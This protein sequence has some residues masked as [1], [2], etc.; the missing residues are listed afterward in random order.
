[1]TTSR[2]ES[3]DHA[4]AEQLRILGAVGF[5]LTSPIFRRGSGVAHAELRRAL[6]CEMGYVL[7]PTEGGTLLEAM[8]SKG[9]IR[10]QGQVYFLTDAG[11]A[12]GNA[13]IDGMTAIAQQLRGYLDEAARVFGIVNAG[14]LRH[15]L[16]SALDHLADTAYVAGRLTIHRVERVLT[17]SHRDIEQL[18][19]ALVCREIDCPSR[20]RPAVS[21][22]LDV[23]KSGESRILTLLLADAVALRTSMNYLRDLRSSIRAALLQETGPIHFV[24]DTSFL[25]PMALTPGRREQGR[26]CLADAKRAGIVVEVLIDTIAEYAEN[27]RTAEVE[28]RTAFNSWIKADRSSE[29]EALHDW[30][31][32]Q[33]WFIQ[34]AVNH[35]ILLPYAEA[36]RAKNTA[37]AN[38]IIH[39]FVQHL[40]RLPQDLA[41]EGV[42][43][44]TTPRRSSAQ[45]EKRL[46]KLLKAESN[47]GEMQLRHDVIL[48]GHVRS[49]RA[50]FP[51]TYVASTDKLISLV[52]RGAVGEND[53][54]RPDVSMTPLEL[55][56]LVNSVAEDGPPTGSSQRL[57]ESWALAPLALMNSALAG[58]SS[59]SA[60][61]QTLVVAD[62]GEMR[63][64]NQQPRHERLAAM[65]GSAVDNR[66][67]RLEQ[68]NE[69]IRTAPT[70]EVATPSPVDPAPEPSPGESLSGRQ[71]K[72][73]RAC[74]AIAVVAALIAALSLAG[75]PLHRPFSATVTWIGSHSSDA[76]HIL[77]AALGLTAATI[78]VWLNRRRSAGIAT[79]VLQLVMTLLAVLGTWNVVP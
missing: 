14:E 19:T 69:A 53:L 42:F 32:N 13:L 55:S 34:S 48:M 40:E 29:P 39:D 54:G 1:M 27:L 8:K 49:L 5:V 9:W 3:D 79:L 16:L 58:S 71:P 20:F 43:I 72:S 21:Y 45:L 51:I 56:R 2:L 4:T 67:A 12:V 64:R 33:K 28:I 78:E 37:Q 52:V 44:G 26:M 74:R 75:L 60:R 61:L 76:M 17:V 6:Q 65:I 15:W 10:Q 38:R 62:H 24:L 25:V 18:D 41:R 59:G 68:V 66:L 7:G 23:L 11:R 50:D 57:R 30:F 31:E 46:L 70:L 47:R 22:L 73:R 36:R 35:R 63:D 77:I